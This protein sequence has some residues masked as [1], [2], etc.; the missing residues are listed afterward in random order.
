MKNIGYIYKI[1]NLI[2]NKVYIGQTKNHYSERFKQHKNRYNQEYRESYNYPLYKAMRKYGL[3][4][5]S[6]EPI[7]K[8]EIDKL[9]EREIYWISFYDSFNKIK[10]YNQTLGGGGFRV[11]NFD[12]KELIEI[13]INTMIEI[14]L[15]LNDIL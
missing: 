12:E 11:Y 9:D 8:C 1:T 7:E 10:G 4:N 2:N 14:I 5:F 13:F 3:D 6:F 15:D